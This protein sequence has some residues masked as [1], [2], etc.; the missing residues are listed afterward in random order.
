MRNGFVRPQAIILVIIILLGLLTVWLA[1]SSAQAAA[2]NQQRIADVRQIQTA[3]NIFFKANGFYPYG[4]SS[5]NGFEQY[6]NHW[7]TPSSPTAGCF[8]KSDV[9]FYS[10]QSSGD[11]YSVT[12]CLGAK[13][14]GFGAG[15]HTLTSKGIQ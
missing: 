13:T 8:K 14:Q 7:P 4:N 1:F 5:P 10:S 2:N 3:L 15:I 6:L 9:Y 12:F 11:D